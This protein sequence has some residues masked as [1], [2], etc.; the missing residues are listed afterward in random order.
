MRISKEK[1]DEYKTNG[2][3]FEDYQEFDGESEY[4]RP[5]FDDLTSLSIDDIELPEFQKLFKEKYSI[6]V[7]TYESLHPHSDC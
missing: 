1:F 3:P 6:A 7:K 5:I 2:M 4:C